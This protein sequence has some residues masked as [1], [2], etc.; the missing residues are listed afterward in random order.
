MAILDT[1]KVL[2]NITDT[3]K[4]AI[5]THYVNNAQN[6]ANHICNQ[7]VTGFDDAIADLAVY[8]FQNKDAVGYKSKSITN[9]KSISYE[10]GIPTSIKQALPIPTVNVTIETSD[11]NA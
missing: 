2:L 3:S 10:L 8:L 7:V 4:D 1:V 5:L 6:M 11:N 9:D